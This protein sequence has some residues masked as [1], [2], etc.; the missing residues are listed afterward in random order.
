MNGLFHIFAKLPIMV[1][2]CIAGF[3][4]PIYTLID[5]FLNKIIYT[6]AVPK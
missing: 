2:P 5:S 6:F 4:F 3:L 1:C